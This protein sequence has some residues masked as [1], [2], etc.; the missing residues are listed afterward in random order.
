MEENLGFLLNKATRL[1]KWE[2]DKG[3]KVYGLTTPQWSVLI[4]LALNEHE[5][6]LSLSPAAIAERL[7]TDRPTMS[8]VIDRL[9]KKGLVTSAI[10]PEDRR[11]QIIRITAE[12]KVLLP[13][14]MNLSNSILNRAVSNLTTEEKENLKKSLYK[15]ILT[16][17]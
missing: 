6:A 1:M 3:L 8:G 15:I 17:S 13:E 4:D 14:L 11:S 7:N 10:N 2:L 12:A 16:L 9:V 5:V